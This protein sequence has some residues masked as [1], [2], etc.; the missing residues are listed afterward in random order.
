MR[1]LAPALLLLQASVA[2]I[3]FAQTPRR[4]VRRQ[5]VT[6][7]L[8][9]T[10]FA[11]ARART[12]LARARAAR[13]A[14]DSALS[15]YDAKTYQR[16]SVGMSVRRIG[17]DRLL[18]RTEQAAR[19]RWARGSNVLVEP[20]GRRT[21]FPMGGADLD[22]TAATPIPYFP[23]REAL[24]IPFDAMGGV[25][26]AEVNENELLHPLA[27]GAEAYYATRPEIP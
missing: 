13:I 16:L 5:P 7:E 2:T 23:G 26:Q 6:P 3:A 8:E 25:V 27:A 10:A 24:W 1:L 11:D 19:V 9:R 15:A 21:A 17:R 22:L 12:L 4:P 18:L 20:T 14:Q